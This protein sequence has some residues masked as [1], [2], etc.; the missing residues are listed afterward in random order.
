A[1]AVARLRAAG[2]VLFGKTNLY[3]LGMGPSGINPHHG[4]ARN[5]YHPEHDT[6]GSS[7]GSAAAV[8]AGVVP[9]ALGTDSGGSV[10]VP[11]DLCGVAS[12]KPTFGR[13]PTDGV[14][15]AFWSL[16]HCGLIGAT[17]RDVHLALAITE[18]QCA[19]TSLPS[20]GSLPRQGSLRIGVCESWW[21]GAKT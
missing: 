4:V 6:G 13:I 21:R 12:L 9:I 14:R 17:V 3:E 5:P 18:G 16:G 19:S 8:A 10:R 2:A 1:F 20:L 11:A 7:S 15:M